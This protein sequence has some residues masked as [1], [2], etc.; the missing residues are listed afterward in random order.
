MTRRKGSLGI[1]A[2]GL[3]VAALALAGPPAG[4]APAPAGGAA[5]AR[6]RLAL[7]VRFWDRMSRAPC[8]SSWCAT[9][10]ATTW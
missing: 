10:A 1:A 9:R 8:P 3:T 5:D 7:D 4:G 6:G 2:L